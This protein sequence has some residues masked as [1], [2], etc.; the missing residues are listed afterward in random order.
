MKKQ[1]R[2]W[3][4]QARAHWKEWRPTMYQELKEAGQLEQALQD[5]A[6]RTA[7]EQDELMDNGYGFQEAWMIVR[8]RYLIV[9]PEEQDEEPPTEYQK[10][11]Q[12]LQDLQ[13]ETDEYLDE[14]GTV[15][16]DRPDPTTS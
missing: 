8:N 9:S 3:V 15:Q 6:N 14:L 1:L 5:A 2:G 4:E 10:L 13:R 11:M 12:E 16:I 7:R